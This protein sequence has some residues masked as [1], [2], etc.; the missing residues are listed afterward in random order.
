MAQGV[1]EHDADKVRNAVTALADWN[2]KNP[3]APIRV[4]LAQIHNLVREMAIG[5]TT[6]VLKSAP[7]EMRVHEAEGLR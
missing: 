2:R 7:K 6:R 5:Q 4:T 1:F 3:E